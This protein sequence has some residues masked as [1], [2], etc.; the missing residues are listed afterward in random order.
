MSGT[1]RK[2]AARSRRAILGA[3]RDLYRDDSGT[4]F[5]EIAHA[6]GVGQA[7]VY[8]HFADRRALLAELADEDMDRL[9]ERLAAE[10]VGPRSLEALLDE[11]V[12]SFVSSQGMI[13]AIRAGE[14][15]ETRVR[16]LTDRTRE[17][18]APRLEAAREARRVRD[19]LTVEDLLIVLAM[20]DGALTAAAERGERETAARRAFEIALDG[21]LRRG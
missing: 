2:D 11:I 20:V 18:L 5:A 4:S 21:L 14:V 19:D 15:E 16:R 17:L 12:A 8:R 3:A 13:E 9:E 1:L 6:A 10:P 7:T